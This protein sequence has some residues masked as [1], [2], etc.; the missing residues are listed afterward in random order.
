MRLIQG[1][2][3]YG[4]AKIEVEPTARYRESW[5]NGL[6]KNDAFTLLAT[7]PTSIVK[8]QHFQSLSSRCP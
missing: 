8:S 2:Q 5:S 7:L 4:A 6:R 1:T 3:Q